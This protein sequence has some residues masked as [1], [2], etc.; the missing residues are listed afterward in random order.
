MPSYKLSYF[1][2]TAL[3]EPIRFLFSYAGI[4]F[5]DER[6]DYEKDWPKLKPT[7]PFGKVP[8]LEVDGKKIDQSVAIGRYLA[9]QC[10]LVG[11]NDWESLEID[12]TVDTIHDLRAN[13]A[14]FH[15]ESNEQA[16]EEKLK[17][18]KETVPY[19]L[20][21]LDAQVKKNGGYFVGGTLTWADLT[22]V[23]LLDYLN[24]M[25]NEDIV[26]KYENLKQLQ[27]KVEEL[28]AI[29]SWI[30]KRPPTMYQK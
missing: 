25:M 15:Y 27:K 11:K 12:A 4:E 20:E 9:K 19:Y 21:R 24:Y 17:A 13:I 6:F 28:P 30:K 1:T 2:A 7:M 3:G 22:F 18:A 23:A 26:E 29:K 14:G 10:G 8:V 16:K 5:V